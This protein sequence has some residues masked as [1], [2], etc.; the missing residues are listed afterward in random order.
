MIRGTLPM[1]AY[2]PMIRVFFQNSVLIK[3]VFLLAKIVT[4]NGRIF[5][6]FIPI[7]GR[8]LYCLF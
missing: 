1:Y 6:K 4:T 7:K 8:A 3:D 5:T 2:V